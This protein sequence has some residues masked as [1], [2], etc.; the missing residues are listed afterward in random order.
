MEAID[1]W[2]IDG[3]DSPEVSRLLAGWAGNLV[4]TLGPEVVRELSRFVG[5]TR[6]GGMITVRRTR[7]GFTAQVTGPIV[8]GGSADLTVEVARELERDV[9]EATTEPE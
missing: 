7:D 2:A 3:R 6:A 9:R 8:G 5:T 1:P 4:R